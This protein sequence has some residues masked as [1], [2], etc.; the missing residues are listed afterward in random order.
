MDL[1]PQQVTGKRSL[2]WLWTSSSPPP[3]RQEYVFALSRYRKARKGPP[4]PPPKPPYDEAIAALAALD[5]QQYPLKGMVREYVFEL[6]EIVKR[7]SERRF[8]VNAA[9]FTTEEMLAWLRFPVL[10]RS[11]G[12]LWSGFTAR[13]I[14]SS[15]PN[16]CL[17]RAP[18]D[19][20]GVEVRGFC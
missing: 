13:P 11:S 14:R 18:F 10:Q 7:Y 16:I 8:G 2:C 12:L 17:I 3:L 6:S 1:K 20:F 15:S 19:R 4:P 5:A 9:E